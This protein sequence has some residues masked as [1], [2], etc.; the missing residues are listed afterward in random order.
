M[1]SWSS[2][3]EKRFGLKTAKL[4]IINDDVDVTQL[5]EEFKSKNGQLFIIRCRS[6]LTNKIYQLQ[7]IGFFIT[8]TILTFSTSSCA[9]A[10]NKSGSNIEVSLAT[11]KDGPFLEQI[12]KKAFKDYRGHYHNNPLLD[13]NKCAEVYIDWAQRLCKEKEIADAVFIARINKNPAGFA[14]CK[15]I[16]K[17]TAKA[18]LLGVDPLFRRSGISCLLHYS[19]WK[20]CVENSVNEFY[21]ETSLNNVNY[22]N[23][24]NKIGFHLCFSTQIFHL[25]NL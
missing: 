7:N 19:R 12:A 16:E 8:D 17:N 18:G 22:I 15:I 13:D 20:W 5:V 25:I 3:D 10:K 11:S 1:F 9:I 23:N 2:L 24:L 14:S 21:V 4:S 6:S